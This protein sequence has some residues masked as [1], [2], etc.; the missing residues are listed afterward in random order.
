M[1]KRAFDKIGSFS[2][3][4]RNLLLLFAMG[5]VA[6]VG[7]QLIQ[8]LFPVYLQ[9]LDASE[10]EISLVI[11]LSSV[12]GTA[13]MLPAGYIIDRVGEKKMLLLGILLWAVSTLFI[14]LAKNWRT[15]AFLY[16]FHGIAE[17]FVGPARMT[18]VLGG[19]HGM[20]GAPAGRLHRVLLEPHPG[21][22]AG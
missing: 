8:P 21:S 19:E 16:V 15:V 11:S 6:V 14:A 20:T 9:S 12:V 1:F 18:L 4:E 3:L 22:E 10:I 13:L 2:R 7:L 17:A 5:L